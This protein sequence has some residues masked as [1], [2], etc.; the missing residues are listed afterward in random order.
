MGPRC[1]SRRAAAR[2]AAVLGGPLV[3]VEDLGRRLLEDQ[4]ARPQLPRRP[5]GRPAGLVVQPRRF[6]A[7]TVRPPH[8]PRPRASYSPWIEAGSRPLARAASRIAQIA[9]PRALGSAR[10]AARAQRSRTSAGGRAPSG[11]AGEE[12]GEM[13]R[14]RR[15]ATSSW[16]D[17]LFTEWILQR[18]WGE[19]QTMT[20]GGEPTT[21]NWGCK[22]LRM[23]KATWTVAICEGLRTGV[24][25][26]MGHSAL[27]ETDVPWPLQGWGISA[28]VHGKGIGGVG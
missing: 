17:I 15:S 27:R 3:R 11:R 21:V 28:I 12:P 4:E 24:G 14:P 8:C 19:T 26:S 20:R 1:P 18:E 25:K 23:D 7:G 22:G 13:P 2:T 5:E 9:A 16:T 6:S 10:A